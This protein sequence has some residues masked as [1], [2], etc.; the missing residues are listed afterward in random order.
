MFLCR[1][2]KNYSLLSSHTPAYI[3]L[4]VAEIGQVVSEE[5]SFHIS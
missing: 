5:K 3:E 2:E 1:I 4:C